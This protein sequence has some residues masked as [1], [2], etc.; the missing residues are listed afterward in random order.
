MKH[1]LL[2]LVGLSICQ[3]AYSQFRVT[4]TI[5]NFSS[6]LPV[7]GAS[8]TIKESKEATHTDSAG[9]FILPTILQR[10]TLQ[11]THIEYQ[12]YQQIVNSLPIKP[13]IVFLKNQ[14][15]DLKEVV[16]STGYQ[17][18]PKERATGSFTTVNN[19]TFNEQTGTSVLSRLEAV[20]NGLIADRSTNGGNGRLMIRGLST[21]QGPKDP[22][23]ILDNF[24]FE[25][26][27]NN[28]NPNDV[29]DITILKDAAASSIWGTRAGN[30]VIVITT[31]KGKLNQKLNINLNANV[32]IGDKPDLFYIRQISSTDF[33]TVENVLFDKGYYNSQINSSSKPALSPVIELLTKRKIATDSEVASIDAEI[34]RLRSLDVR[35][36]YDKY[37]YNQSINHQY[38]LN[39]SGGSNIMGW[40]ISSGY[41]NNTSVLGAEYSRLNL[42]L[43]NTLK[44]IK[45]LEINTG[46]Y[47]TQSSSEN[48]KP[49]YGEITSKNSALFPYAEFAD[50]DG[51]PLPLIKDWR[52]PYIQSAGNGKLLDWKYYPMDDYKKT[53]NTTTGNSVLINTG[54][55]YRLPWGFNADFKYQYERQ[56]TNARNVQ[57]A[58]SYAARNLINGYTQISPSGEVIYKVP[59]GGILD[60]SNKLLQSNNIRGQLNFDK[61]LFDHRV[62]AIAGGEIRN[63]HTTG[64]GYRQYGYNDDLLTFGNVDYTVQYPNF[65]SGSKSFIPSNSALSDELTRF[66]SLFA[67]AAYTYKGKYTLSSSVRRDA[68]NL[69]GLNTNDKW[70]PLWSSGVSWNISKEDFYRSAM[71]PYLKLR[72]TYGYNGNADPSKSAVT[73]MQYLNLSPN[74]LTPYAQF[75]KYANPELKWESIRMINVGI[76]FSSKNSRI[77]GSIE[78]YKKKGTD[79]FGTSPLDYTT[80]IGSTVVKNVAAIKGSGIDIELNSLNI[81]GEFKWRTNLN[82][83]R[84]NDQVTEYYL[85]NRQGSSFVGSTNNIS[86]ILGKPVYSIFAYR[87]AG[88]DPQTGEPMGFLNN[89]VSKAYAQITSTGTQIDDLKFYG[90]A[91]PTTYGSLGNTFIYRSLSLT[92]RITYKF[93]YYFR[94]SSINYPNLY[95]GWVGHSD[96]AERWQQPGDELKTNI[97]AF[98]YPFSTAMNSLYAFSEPLIER[99]D[100]IRLQYINLGYELKKEQWKGLPVKSIQLYLNINNLGLLWR[101][102]K[103][104]LDPEAYNAT[105]Y[106]QPKNYAFGLRTNF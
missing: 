77:N 106:P 93:G 19:R 4:G 20:A 85:Q 27:L 82:F 90:S 23:I 64:D 38:A 68:S 22:L 56:Q 2:L 5:K 36:D 92:F 51:H 18:L 79:L 29:E 26:D 15:N 58:E 48:G 84:N 100:H 65:V 8:V 39:L 40:I 67:N 31:K 72:A 97:P 78:Y 6:T 11:I 74:T 25:G 28:I 69:F 35:N 34:N 63:I 50:Q 75:N 98:I 96:F 101:A 66:V 37:F 41:D 71:L 104:G 24:P 46:L 88:L 73:T 99:G 14:S 80:G 59:A 47:Y 53:N 105:S 49:G 44:P 52:Q 17:Q 13:I 86:G 57:D 62:S 70:K 45:N 10:F 33:I 87:W 55:N 9:N 94:R 3:I 30:G 16:I 89:E 60:I 7:A 102:N 95:S 61:E 81:D 76:D 42:R 83:S 43:Q 54:V 12:N 1:F 32:T 103:E 91:I 21:I